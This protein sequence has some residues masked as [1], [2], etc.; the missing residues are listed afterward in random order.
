MDKTKQKRGL[1]GDAPKV[2]SPEF[3]LEAVKRLRETANATALALELGVRRNQL[4]KWSKQLEKTGV[5]GPLEGALKASQVF[6]NVGRPPVEAEDELSR[7]RRENKRLELENAIL[8][9]AEAY[10]ARPKR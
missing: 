9:K 4:Y 3:K 8:K 1:S 10:F 6:K 2:F 5:V 7:L